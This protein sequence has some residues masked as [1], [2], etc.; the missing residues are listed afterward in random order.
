MTDWITFKDAGTSLTGKTRIWQVRVRPE[1]GGQLLGYVKWFGGWRRYAFYPSP[2][3]I[4]DQGCL[5][6]IAE[7]CATATTEKASAT[8]EAK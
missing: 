3:T 1:Q 8:A 4:F 6:I 5:L 2:E 7:F